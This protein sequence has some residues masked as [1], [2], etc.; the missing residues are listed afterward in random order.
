MTARHV[1]AVSGM[2][3]IAIITIVTVVLLNS[4][5]TPSNPP[6]SGP[7]DIASDNRSGL[8]G[9][10]EGVTPCD[11]VPRP[12]PD[13]PAAADCDHMTWELTLHQSPD[14]Q[15][16]EAATYVLNGR[17]GRSQPN[18][19][20]G[21]VGGGTEVTRT[22]S[23][24]IIR[25]ADGKP[26]AMIY[27]LNWDDAGSTIFFIKINDNLL[28]LLDRNKQLRIGHGGWSYTLNR[29]DE[30]LSS[31]ASFSPY[32]PSP[33]SS[34]SAT[35][36]EFVGRTLCRPL[37]Q[38]LGIPVSDRCTRIK[39]SI[40]LYQDPVTHAPTTYTANRIDV[41]SS[42]ER[43][44]LEGSWK[45]VR[46]EFGAVIYQLDWPE[47]QKTLSLMKAD[48]NHLFFLDGDMNLRT[49]DELWS[50]TLSRAQ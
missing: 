44:M 18:T 21:H 25:G 30:A 23:W 35:P 24:E 8:F 37:A 26:D 2:A 48:D 19:P 12:L 15:A 10:F 17:Y 41:G 13:I 22:G 3:A 5:H 29:T 20:A 31:A 7:R 6:E 9:V 33:S 16:G 11:T 39:W 4:P 27:Q 40:T 47:G 36:G 45:A 1:V 43:N 42:D 46:N 38:Q 14:Q 49:G 28:H 32:A 34:N 50:Y